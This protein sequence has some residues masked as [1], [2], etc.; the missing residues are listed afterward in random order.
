VTESCTAIVEILCLVGLPDT[1]DNDSSNVDTSAEL[2][3]SFSVPSVARN[4]SGNVSATLSD[5]VAEPAT[6]PLLR[7]L[8][9]NAC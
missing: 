7:P 3:A 1:S 5:A 4:D 2:A 8:F 6:L 9:A